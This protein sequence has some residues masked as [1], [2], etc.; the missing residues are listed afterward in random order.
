MTVWGRQ[1]GKKKSKRSIWRQKAVAFARRR[2]IRDANKISYI[3]I[4]LEKLHMRP[5]RYC[6]VE[7]REPKQISIDHLIPLS[8]GGT[9][10]THNL[11]AMHTSCN[12]AKGSLTESEFELLI[13]IIKTRLGQRYVAY[14]LKRMAIG[15]KPL[16]LKGEDQ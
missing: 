12:K 13:E 15:A 8:R 4:M 1:M 14:I 5:C 11:K 3:E 10:H 6:G 16:K 2:Q 9:D 7:L